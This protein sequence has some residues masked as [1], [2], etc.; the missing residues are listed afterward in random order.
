MRNLADEWARALVDDFTASP[1]EWL[2]IPVHPAS[3]TD[4]IER[5]CLLI[6][7]TE[8]ARAHPRL[9]VGVIEMELHWHRNDGAIPAARDLLRLAALEMDARRSTITIPDADMTWFMPD[10]DTEDVKEDGFVLRST[11]A[12]RFR[13]ASVATA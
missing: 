6:R 1:P 9:A 10:P 3:T 8:E 7:G 11:R 4:A 5:P 12:V 13:A 2:A